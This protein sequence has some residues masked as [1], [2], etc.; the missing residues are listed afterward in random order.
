MGSRGQCSGDGGRGPHGGGQE[1]EREVVDRMEKSRMA[2]GRERK[3]G[4]GALEK[5]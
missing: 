5:E 1:L 3:A 2:I 4:A